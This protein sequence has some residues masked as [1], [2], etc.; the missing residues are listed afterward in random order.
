MKHCPQERE[1]SHAKNQGTLLVKAQAHKKPKTKINAFL[2]IVATL[3][4]TRK[5]KHMQRLVKK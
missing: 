1:R 4:K 2:F 3:L 5:K